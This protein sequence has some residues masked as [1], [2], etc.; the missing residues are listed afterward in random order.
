LN[1]DYQWKGGKNVRNRKDMIIAVLVIFCLAAIVFTIV[2]VSS[3]G[4]WPYNPWWDITDDGKIDI[5][6][7]AR[8][9][10]A[11]GTYGQS[12]DKASIQYD[13]GWI[14][15][16]DKCGQ[17]IVVTH[18]LNST[19]L[20]VDI[21]GKTSLSSGSHQRNY[22]LAGNMMWNKNYGIVGSELARSMV[23]AVDGGY[24]IAG[25]AGDDAWL[26]KTDASGT[27]VWSKSYG[28]TGHDAVYSL[29]QTNDRG[30]ALAGYTD[31]FGAGNQ[32]FWLVKTDASGNLQWNKAYGGTNAEWAYVLAQTS[33]GGYALA[34]YTRSF[35]A[36]NGDFWL[37]KTDS[38]GNHLW[39]KTY[40]GIGDD[41]AYAL[42]QTGD[43]GY[44][45][46]GYTKSFGVGDRDFWFVKT[47][48]DGNMQW[49]KTY[50]GTG[51]EVAYA[52]V[53]TGDGGYALAGYTDSFGAGNGDAWLIKTDA[54]GNMVWNETYGGTGSD[55]ASSAVQTSD[56]GYALAGATSS[57]GAGLADMWLVKTDTEGNMQ[58]NQ[59]YG[60]AAPYSDWAS[61]VVQTS[62]G[63][64]ALTGDLY[65]YNPSTDNFWLVK[66][67]TESGLAWVEST[68]TSITLYRG[69][70]DINWNYVRVRLWQPKQTP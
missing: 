46:A 45:I 35:G 52:L 69:S 63:G 21:Q 20:I 10:G 34:G 42:T 36:G 50:G 44:A 38:L 58:W 54:D 68:S 41:E 27:K 22:G 57:F 1:S 12:I 2:P 3:S 64:Y 33:D 60:E 6:D 53:Q 48:A 25:Q 66:A 16:T 24:A 55:G 13:S 8:V 37:V 47:D 40:G 9:S 32:D 7:L 39:N 43:G 4:A 5:D 29:V 70:T 17:N 18:G 15:I 56:G 11:F 31:S 26:V 23:Q 59:T 62:D 14:N 67:A 49:N 61:C 51:Y 19:D 65:A 30:Y 28:G